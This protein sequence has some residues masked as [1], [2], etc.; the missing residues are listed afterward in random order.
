MPKTDP[1]QRPM[2]SES[3]RKVGVELSLGLGPE[4]AVERNQHLVLPAGRLGQSSSVSSVA[5]SARTS[6]PGSSTR[7]G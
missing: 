7:L 4:D 3:D 2:V 5:R 6:S 1:H